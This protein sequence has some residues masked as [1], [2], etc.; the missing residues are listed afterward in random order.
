MNYDTVI[1]LDNGLVVE[2]DSP[3]NLVTYEKGVFASLMNKNKLL[4]VWHTSASGNRQLS[5]Q[6]QGLY[7]HTRKQPLAHPATLI[8]N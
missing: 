6:N 8:P 1:V 5:M 2:C 3:Q 7:I 4:S